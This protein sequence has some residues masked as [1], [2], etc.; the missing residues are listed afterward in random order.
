MT[1]LLAEYENESNC[2]QDKPKEQNVQPVENTT[3][4]N[5]DEIKVT[6][7]TQQRKRVRRSEPNE[8]EDEDE[9]YHIQ[10]A[11]RIS[12]KQRERYRLQTA[13]GRRIRSENRK[14]QKAN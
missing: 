11:R 6:P 2:E 7:V 8:K 9:E 1:S 12:K 5:A 4:P 13:K 10:K 3:V 14:K